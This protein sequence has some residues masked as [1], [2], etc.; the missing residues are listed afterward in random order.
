MNN[1]DQSAIEILTGQSTDEF[2]RGAWGQDLA[3]SRESAAARALLGDHAVESLDDF[4]SSPVSRPDFLR[5]VKSGTEVPRN[6]YTSV[7]RNRGGGEQDLLDAAKLLQL[8]HDG[9]TVVVGALHRFHP[10]VAD[11][12]RRLSQEIGHPVGVNSYLTPNLSQGL[13]L[14]YDTHDVFVVQIVGSKRWT[15]RRPHKPRLPTPEQEWALLTTEEREGIL[16]EDRDEELTLDMQAGDCLYL[17]RGFLHAAQST[18]ELSVHLTIAVYPR[19][20]RDLV[21]AYLDVLTAKDPWLREESRPSTQTDLHA[22]GDELTVAVARLQSMLDTVETTEV[23]RSLDVVAATDTPA[24]PIRVLN[25]LLGAAR[26]R[27][28]R[29]GVRRDLRLIVEPDS[30]TRRVSARFG[31]ETFRMPIAAA[32]ALQRISSGIDFTADELTST[33]LPEKH[34][35]ALIQTLAKRGVIVPVESK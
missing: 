30:N 32:P 29:F 11:F 21:R 24:A 22:L 2:L 17:P 35:G 25:S 6:A 4:L 27:E 14:H 34:A 23:G 7:R 28:A 26:A 8:F 16:A 9:H 33:G 19:L 12:A 3:H 1:N 31:S 15:V 10:T 13:N 18:S 20:R 5:V